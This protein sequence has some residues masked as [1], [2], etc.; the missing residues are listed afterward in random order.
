M[1]ER[2]EGKEKR[3]R[4]LS[5]ERGMRKGNKGEG[6]DERQRYVEGRGE[7]KMSEGV[8]HCSGRRMKDKRKERK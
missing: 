7:R 4:G 3:K 5:E 8:K 2:K 6:R 1:K